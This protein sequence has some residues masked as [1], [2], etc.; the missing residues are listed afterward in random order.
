MVYCTTLLDFPDTFWIPDAHGPFR[1][2]R[3]KHPRHS[4]SWLECSELRKRNI[5]RSDFACCQHP[6]TPNRKYQHSCLSGVHIIESY[7]MSGWQQCLSCFLVGLL[8][9]TGLDC[10]CF[11]FF[12][13]WLAVFSRLVKQHWFYVLSLLFFL[14]STRGSIYSIPL[15]EYYMQLSHSIFIHD[16]LLDKNYHLYCHY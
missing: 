8:R 16:N 3:R 7:R 11:Q 12:Q 9:S 1:I 13:Q 10:Q 2:R 15:S 4:S 6:G 5:I 14:E